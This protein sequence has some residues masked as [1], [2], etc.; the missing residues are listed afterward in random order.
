M[1]QRREFLKSVAAGSL[2][3]RIKAE[4]SAAR[5]RSVGSGPWSSP[6]TW[7]NQHVPV[8]GSTVEILPG[9]EVVYDIQTDRA[10]RMVH[11]LGK[12]SFSRDGIRGW[13]S[14]C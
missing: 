4:A 12:L 9:H 7:E 10:F 3:L 6:S 8:P 1:L 2:A 14:A 5:V 11:V 13:M